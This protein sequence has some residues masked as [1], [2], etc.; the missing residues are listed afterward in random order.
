MARRG[1]PRA[2][3]PPA[4]DARPV[5]SALAAPAADPDGAPGA[6]LIRAGH[7][8]RGVTYDGRTR[9]RATAAEVA[10]LRRFNAIVED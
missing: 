3:T 10:L 1:K 2:A 5:E 6:V 8:H 9:C 7:T 4:A